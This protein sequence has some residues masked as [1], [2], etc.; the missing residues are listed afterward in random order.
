M[1]WGVGVFQVG[2]ER[3]R[4]SYPQLRKGA[5]FPGWSPSR[6]GQDLRQ[7]G[8][9]KVPRHNELKETEG[10]KN[11]K[12]HHARSLRKWDTGSLLVSPRPMGLPAA[13]KR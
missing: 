6:M 13:S 11:E 2:E 1:A 7:G 4:E 5:A 3:G 10:K 12:S 9:R 8:L